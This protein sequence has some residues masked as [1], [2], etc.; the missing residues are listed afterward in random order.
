MPSSAANSDCTADTENLI[1]S[2]RAI[3]GIYLRTDR[4]D[5]PV[6]WL[7]RADG[8]TSSK[9]DPVRYSSLDKKKISL[10]RV[11]YAVWE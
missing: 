7:P 10:Q 9:P 5:N 11:N 6:T 8:V 3:E 2:S 4:N 1:G